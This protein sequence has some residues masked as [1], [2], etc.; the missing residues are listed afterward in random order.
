MPEQRFKL[1][2]PAFA[3]ARIAQGL[4]LKDVAAKIGWHPVS[5]SNL[6]ARGRRGELIP[7]STLAALAWA[8][9]VNLDDLVDLAKRNRSGPG[10]HIKTQ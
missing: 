3:A 5:L 10:V 6:L 1:D 4:K 7:V 8:L 2:L 9:D